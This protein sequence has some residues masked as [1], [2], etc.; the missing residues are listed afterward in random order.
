MRRLPWI[1][2][3]PAGLLLGAAPAY[4]ARSVMVFVVAED[5]GAESSTGKLATLTS[6][7]VARNAG[8]E[9]VDLRDAAGDAVPPDIRAIRK[10]ADADLEA[11]KKAFDDGTLEP[12][13]EKFR[14]AIKQYES[15]APALEKVE[16]YVEAHMYLAASLQLRNKQEDAKDEVIDALAIRPNY[17]PAGKLAGGA[18][19][20]LLR[21]AKKENGEVHRGSASFTTVPPGGKV[22]IDGEF[23]GFSP[24]SVDHLAVG[25][26]VFVFERAGYY[27]GG[28]VADVTS[29]DDLELKGRF[30]PTKDYADIEDSVGAMGQEL[31]SATAGPNTWKVLSRFKVD[32]ALIVNLRTS[33]DTLVIDLALVDANGKKRL[34]KRRTSFEGEEYGA[35]SHEVTRLVNGVLSD[36]EAL[37][38]GGGK[39]KATTRDPLDGVSGEEDWDDEKSDKMS[40]SPGNDDKPKKGKKDSSDD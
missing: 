2:L 17:K 13:E 10:A 3:V 5:K 40:T 16:N 36:A 19:A 32:R 28:S 27:N 35:V 26:H 38:K 30:N 9:V 14:S 29:V 21:A 4:G 8:Y 24:L 33:G 18:F 37:E 39:K 31:D 22:F 34:A 15:C 11:G 7:A 1:T 20:D 6:E 12:A 23:K 25:K